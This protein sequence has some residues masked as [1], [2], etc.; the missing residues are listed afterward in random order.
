MKGYLIS[1]GAVFFA[2]ALFTATAYAAVENVACGQHYNFGTLKFTEFYPEKVAYSQGDEVNFVYTMENEFG[3]PLVEGDVKALVMYR[4]PTDVDRIE[5]DDIVDDFYAKTDV[6][7][8]TADKYKGSF[9]WKIPAKAKPGIYAVNLYFPVKKKFN[10]AGLT[11]MTSVPGATTT[12]EV[13]GV[14]SGNVMLEKTSTQ[15]NGNKYGFRMPIPEVSLNAPVEIKTKLL[16]P[17]KET[18]TITYELFGW[19]D[20]EKKL[21]QYTKTETVA[22]AKDLAYS[23]PGLPVGVYVARITATASDWKSILKTRF[24]VKGSKGRFIWVGLD[25]FPI[26]SGDSTKVG[27]CLS[28]SAVSPGDAS[29]NFTVRGTIQVKD[30]GGNVLMKEDY[31]RPITALIDGLQAKFTAPKDSTKLTVFADMYDQAGNKM[32]EVEIVYDYSKFL[33]IEKTLT[34]SSPDEC[35]D[36]LEYEVKYTDKYGDPLT[37]EVA[38]YLTSADGKVAALNE[39]KISGTIKDSFTVSDLP[40]GKYTLK[41]VEKSERMSREKSVTCAG[42]SK[43]A[44]VT[45]APKPIVTTTTPPQPQSQIPW[46]PIVLILAILAIAVIAMRSKR[47]K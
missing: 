4:G 44:V 37:G 11:F 8:Q 39:Q 20:V 36:V 22:D 12:F 43:P 42:A 24:F 29:V 21:D 35:K 3:S 19:D 18:A 5:D 46:V 28:N 16:N 25:H 17:G 31:S 40:A 9:V 45:T 7:I 34:L 13:R 10:I 38:V 27:V 47:K 41:V 23:I 26:M 33:N 2:L 6:S 32:D 14:D 15:F 30:S 1:N